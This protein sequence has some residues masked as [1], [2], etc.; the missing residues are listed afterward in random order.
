[1][2]TQDQIFSAAPIATPADFDPDGALSRE[3]L[4]RRGHC[5][6]EGCR[7]CPYGFVS[8]DSVAP[9][10]SA[11]IV[12]IPPIAISADDSAAAISMKAR[13]P[14][15]SGCISSAKKSWQHSAS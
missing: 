11:E 1:M 12:A 9:A 3:Y 10:V 6:Q 8:P 4:L 15:S 7:N 13:R 14:A 2:P 5:C